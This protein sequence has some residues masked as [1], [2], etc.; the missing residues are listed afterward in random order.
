MPRTASAAKQA[1]ASLRRHERNQLART[2]LRS[3]VKRFLTTLQSGKKD[4][5]QALYPKVASS[6][7]KAVKHGLLHRNA[8][9]RRK[10]RF[11]SRLKAT[12]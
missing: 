6:L 8:A 1:R 7:D 12:T 11:A 10:S 3:I 5:A 2:Q 9:D 4:D